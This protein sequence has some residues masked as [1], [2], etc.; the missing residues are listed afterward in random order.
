MNR[1]HCAPQYVDI[2]TR[3]RYV[4]NMNYRGAA[5]RSVIVGGFRVDRQLLLY[6]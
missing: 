5:L 6:Y 2:S 3:T 4:R 1:E